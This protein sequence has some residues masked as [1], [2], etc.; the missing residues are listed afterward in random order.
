MNTA[1]GGFILGYDI[2]QTGTEGLLA[3]SLSLGDGRQNVAVETFDQKTGKILKVITQQSDTKNDFVT[4]GITGKSLGLVEFEHVSNL[5]VDKRLYGMINP[6]NGNKFTRRWTPPLK[7]DDIIQT[8]AE[9]QGS[10][11]SAV[12]GFE[13]GGNFETFV[14]SSDV[15]A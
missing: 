1:L 14:F 15:A 9:S 3:E 13:N 5:F 12:M 7:K 6:L 4:L 2:D 8:V 11:T 10:T